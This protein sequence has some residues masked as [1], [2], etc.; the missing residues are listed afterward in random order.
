MAPLSQRNGP[1]TSQSMLSNIAG[2]PRAALVS[3]IVDSFILS[4]L[5]GR[6]TTIHH[7][8]LAPSG[9]IS[10]TK[11]IAAQLNNVTARPRARPAP[12]FLAHGVP[13]LGTGARSASTRATPGRRFHHADPPRSRWL[14]LSTTCSGLRFIDLSLPCSPALASC[15][16]RG[17][18]GSQMSFKH[19][20]WQP[21]RTLH[22]RLKRPNSCALSTF[23]RQ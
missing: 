10:L 22:A 3:E 23:S 14:H 18:E 9:R 13:E 4:T 21:Q 20:A 2:F 15:D 11:L 5:R 19:R 7:R 16:G 17:S 6:I 1:K 8:S 12:H